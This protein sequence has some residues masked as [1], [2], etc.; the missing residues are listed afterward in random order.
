MMKKIIIFTSFHS[1]EPKPNLE[2]PDTEEIT[3][4]VYR[5]VRVRGGGGGR[6]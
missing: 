4:Q 3:V 6:G 1:V 5:V 2:L